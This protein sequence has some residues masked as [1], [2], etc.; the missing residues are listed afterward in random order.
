MLQN[1]YLLATIGADTAEN[2]RN[3]AEICQKLATTLRVPT[4]PAD[5]AAGAW[6]SGPRTAGCAARDRGGR[7]R[8]SRG[9]R[10]GGIG[11]KLWTGSFSAVSKPMF[12]SKYSFESSRRD[13]HNAFLCD[14]NVCQL[15]P[16]NLQNLNWYGIISSKT[17]ACSP[18]FKL[19]ISL[20]T[21]RWWCR[22][23]RRSR[24]PAGGGPRAG[25]STRGRAAARG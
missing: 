7:L 6:R 15:L 24:A 12:A 2:E 1:A 17:I 25:G 14:L 18:Y 20:R 22:P 9:P 16:K 5:A 4:E 11:S 8:C 3:V 10:Q 19:R 13:P 21:S 23:R